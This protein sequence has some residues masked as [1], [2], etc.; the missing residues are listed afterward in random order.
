MQFKILGPLEVLDGEQSVAVPGAKPRA[1]LAALLLRPGQTV[2]AERLI[3]E[4]WGDEP[5]E[6]AQN[7]LQVYVSQLR[8]ALGPDLV[9]RRSSGYSL[10]ASRASSTSLASRTWSESARDTSFT[11]RRCEVA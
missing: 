3:D 9:T 8:R 4:L 7:T 2:S 5:P 6:T 11:R 10:A 1:L